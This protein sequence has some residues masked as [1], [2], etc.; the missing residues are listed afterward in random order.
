M[1]ALV[2][3]LFSCGSALDD[4]MCD[5]PGCEWTSEDWARLTALANPPDAPRDRSNRHSG[6][7]EVARLGQRLFFDPAFSGRPTMLDAIRR[8]APSARPTGAN[9][10]L[11][12]SCA[13]CHDPRHGGVDVTSSPGHVSVGAGWTDVNAL[14]TFNSAL[15][16]VV[17]WNGRADSLWALNV[18]VGESPTTLNGNRLRTAHVMAGRYRSEY[19]RLFAGSLSE[20]DALPPDGKPG[21]KPGCQPADGTEPFGD[22][23]DC[24]SEKLQH[25]ITTVLVNWAKAIAVYEEKLVSRESDFDFFVN[26]GPTSQRLSARAKRGAR[27]FVGKAGC[28]SC[29]SGPLLSD[30]QFHD[31]GIPQTGTAVPTTADC[32]AG[33]LPCDCVAGRGC[34]PWG[35]FDGLAR[36]RVSPWLRTS[37]WSDDRA[38]LSRAAYYDRP[39]HDRLKG[40]WRTPSLRDVALTAPYMHDGMYRTLR[41]V[42]DHYN[43]GG[44]GGVGG[45]ERVGV[46]AAALKPL[47]LHEDEVTAVVAFLESLNGRLPDEPTAPLP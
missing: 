27:L 40:A 30:G 22:A 39:L 34:A 17:F 7:P 24:L 11:G 25:E 33:A 10:L 32:P 38:D 6:N 2:L 37:I 9:G 21:A 35:A 29:H 13:T 20:V 47:G 26:E 18:I 5:E 45:G 14:S 46:A 12:I 8:P 4:L 23:F 19:E 43:R 16:P 31:I 1:A 28:V 15:Q 42:V 3:P 44:L 41:D 36:L